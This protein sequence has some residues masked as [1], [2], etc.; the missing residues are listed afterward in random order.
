MALRLY[1]EEERKERRKWKRYIMSTSRREQGLTGYPWG[2]FIDIGARFRLLRFFHSIQ[3][4]HEVGSR[5]Y[6]VTIIILSR[7]RHL[8]VLT[9]S[10]VPLICSDAMNN[11]IYHFW[12][13][14]KG[15]LLTIRLLWN[16]LVWK[17]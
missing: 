1:E 14:L 6:F 12:S 9:A 15:L 7:F 2:H 8:T 17:T 16:R 10:R 5:C 3:G 4:F 13:G 11:V